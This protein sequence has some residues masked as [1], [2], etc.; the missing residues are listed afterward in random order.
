VN[1]KLFVG[2]TF[3][4]N[5]SFAKNIES[6]RTRFDTKFQSNPYL[7]LPIIP[8]FEIEVTE[9]K[10]L[11]A[12]LLEELESFFF[13]NTAN[14]SLGI[15]GLDVQE[16]KKNKILYL[17]PL[18]DEDLQFCQESLFAICQSYITDREKKLKDTKKTFLTIGRFQDPLELHTSIDIARKEF[19]EFT[20]LAYESICLFSKSNGIWYREEDLVSF[21]RPS[22]ELLQSSRVS[23]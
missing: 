4:Q 14:H 15:T 20:T 21:D 11:K 1:S 2:L 10:K 5:N 23:L 18:M 17:H 22:D 13:E 3:Y 8:P 7:H 16:H 12:E 6:F 19:Q 9:V